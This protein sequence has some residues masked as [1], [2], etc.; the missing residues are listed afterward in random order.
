[1]AIEP[2]LTHNGVSFRTKVRDKWGSLFESATFSSSD[3]VC[4]P[5]ICDV[6]QA[7]RAAEA[8]ESELVKLKSRGVRADIDPETEECTVVD[9]K[10]K[11]SV[12]TEAWKRECRDGVSAGWKKSQDQMLR[13]H[14]LGAKIDEKRKAGDLEL[15]EFGPRHASL[16]LRKMKEA[17]LSDQMRLH[18]YNLMHGIFEDARE[19]FRVLHDNPVLERYKPSVAKVKRNFLTPSH[20]WQLFDYVG[21]LSGKDEWAKLPV[22]I[23]L[24][25]GLRYEALVGV[26]FEDVIWD[27]DQ[28][29]IRR[30]YKRKTHT[31]EDFPKGKDWEIVHMSPETKKLLAA[32]WAK[33]EKS[34]SDYVCTTPPP[35]ISSKTGQ[36]IRAQRSTPKGVICY[37]TFYKAMKRICKAAGVPQVDPHEL[38]HSHSA[39]LEHLGAS[40]ADIQRRLHHKSSKTTERYR[41]A[42]DERVRRVASM[43]RRPTLHVINGDENSVPTVKTGVFT[44]V[45]Q[46]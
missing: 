37:G 43:V 14:V 27:Y 40:E 3:F 6:P 23:M 44:K 28:I 4:L 18:V 20:A 15:G 33:G 12:F 26:T 10:D 45:G 19:H 24:L 8:F 30:A 34:L 38:R 42:S 29:N 9:V 11:L 22:S 31:V 7:R 39:L 21:G 16:I 32:E 36:P 41:H 13:D 1:M 46:G 5:D 25:E 35:R 2:R 17:G